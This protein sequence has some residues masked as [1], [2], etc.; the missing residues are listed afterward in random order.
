[1]RTGRP[2]LGEPDEFGGGRAWCGQFVG[3]VDPLPCL[4]HLDVNARFVQTVRHAQPAQ[5]RPHH[6]DS[7]L[8][9][10]QFLRYLYQSLDV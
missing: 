2:V 6:Y 9:P 1:M 4:E 5:A 8:T 3:V 7:H 10:G